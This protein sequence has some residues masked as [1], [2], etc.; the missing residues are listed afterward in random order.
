MSRYWTDYYSGYLHFARGEYA[1]AMRILGTTGF[2]SSAVYLSAL[3]MFGTPEAKASFFRVQAENN[4]ND[5]WA[6]GSYADY[7]LESGEVEE[8]IGFGERAVGLMPYRD[9]VETL[10]FAY[11]LRAGSRSNA[12][13][14]AGARSDFQAAKTLARDEPIELLVG[15]RC[16]SRCG[17]IAVTI[18]KF[19][20]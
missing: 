1:E 11:L 19:S 2:K 16:A 6:L 8:S 20:N 3:S 18:R 12:G 17:E 7:L 4:P 13:D 15:E 10:A 14:G 5:A 9:A